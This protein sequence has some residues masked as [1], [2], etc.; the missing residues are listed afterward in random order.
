[1]SVIGRKTFELKVVENYSS[2]LNG[3]IIEGFQYLSM[4]WKIINDQHH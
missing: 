2:D 4:L 3:L 1:M